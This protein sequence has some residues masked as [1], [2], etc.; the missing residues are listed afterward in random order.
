MH[1]SPGALS[2]RVIILGPTQDST[3]VQCA[4]LS[5][6]FFFINLYSMYGSLA[7][8]CSLPRTGGVGVSRNEIPWDRLPGWFHMWREL[9]EKRLRRGDYYL[10]VQM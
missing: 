10:A 4:F 5:R 2:I 8:V 7:P 1:D 3:A 9:G 6:A